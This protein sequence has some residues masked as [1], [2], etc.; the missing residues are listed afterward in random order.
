MMW[1]NPFSQC[2]APLPESPVAGRTAQEPSIKAKA[3]TKRC[4]QLSNNSAQLQPMA[5][6]GA[7]LCSSVLHLLFYLMMAL[8]NKDSSP[9]QEYAKDILQKPWIYGR[10][11]KTWKVNAGWTGLWNSSSLQRGMHNREQTASVKGRLKNQLT[12]TALF[13]YRMGLTNTCV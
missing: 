6:V 10:T 3:L 7:M 2:W 9:E 13:L 12:W 11:G 4:W 8:T 5:K 1:I